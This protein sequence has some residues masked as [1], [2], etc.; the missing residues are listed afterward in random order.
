MI[1]FKGREG[2]PLGVYSTVSGE[3]CEGVRGKAYDGVEAGMRIEVEDCEIRVCEGFGDENNPSR[4]LGECYPRVPEE[5]MNVEVSH[6]DVVNRGVEEQVKIK[7][8]TGRIGGDEG[9]VDST[10][11]SSLPILIILIER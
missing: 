2:T 8:E 6:D 3:Y 7:R 9:D 5:A 11:P 4:Y 1:G 10:S